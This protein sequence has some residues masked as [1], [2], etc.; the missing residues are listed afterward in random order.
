MT[1]NEIKEKLKKKGGKK[2]ILAELEANSKEVV[3]KIRREEADLERYSKIIEMAQAA[4]LDKINALKARKKSILDNDPNATVDNQEIDDLDNRI[5]ELIEDSLAL[6]ERLSKMQLISSENLKNLSA[7]LK[8][9]TEA[10][11]QIGE[12]PEWVNF[13]IG[14]IAKGV[15]SAICIALGY[16][17]KCVILD[18]GGMDKNTEGLFNSFSKAV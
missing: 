10:I 8:A 17:A 18:K 14:G 1:E 5:K 4:N 12:L 11:K 6:E 15:I 9:Q 7:C 13:L 16:A 3:A 2:E